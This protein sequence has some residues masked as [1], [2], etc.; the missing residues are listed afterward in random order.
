MLV[1]VNG[2]FIYLFIYLLCERDKTES[3]GRRAKKRKGVE[4][5]RMKPPNPSQVIAALIGD[6]EQNRIRKDKERNKEQAP[7]LAI[8]DHSVASHDPHGSYCRYILKTP[9]HRGK[10][11]I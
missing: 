3:Q 9:A 11:F 7:N 5:Q 4:A 8:L 2:L 6:E 1:Y 10:H